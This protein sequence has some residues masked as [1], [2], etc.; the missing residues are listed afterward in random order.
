MAKTEQP[1]T[2]PRVK[3]ATAGCAGEGEGEKTYYVWLL[4]DGC[5]EQQEIFCAVDDASA[6]TYV[7]NT[8]GQEGG[9]ERI[10]TAYL[11]QIFYGHNA[12]G[13]AAAADVYFGKTLDQ[14]TAAQAALL[15]A[16]PHTPACYDL[17]RWVP[18]DE[19]GQY[20]RDDQNRLVVPLTGALRCP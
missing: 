14:L 15:A 5:A 9:K 11:N 16:I 19:N 13:I 7:D 17:F 1:A 8:Y 10:I 20:V 18:L 12:Y 4:V 2:T 6:Q 3:G